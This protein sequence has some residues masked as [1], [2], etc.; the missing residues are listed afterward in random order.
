MNPKCFGVK[1]IQRLVPDGPSKES[2]G[3]N[4]DPKPCSFR[5]RGRRSYDRLSKVPKAMA[6]HPPARAVWSTARIKLWPESVVL[7]TFP[8]FAGDRVAAFAGRIG[9][10]DAAAFVAF[11]TEGEECSLT[12]PE[13]AFG[14]W[15]LRSRAL[16]VSRGL[17]AITIDASMPVDLIGF[18]APLAERLARAGIPIIPQCGYRTDHILV[19]GPRVDDAVK[20]IEGLIADARKEGA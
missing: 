20:V 4:K 18:L 9:V 1:V 6:L 8:R 11:V 3:A 10:R 17:R 7:A 2:K 14:S 12:A 5:L 19:P 16:E 15:R 13:G